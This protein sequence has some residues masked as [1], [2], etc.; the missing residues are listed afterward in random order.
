MTARLTGQS[1]DRVEG[2]RLLRGEGRFVGNI[3]HPDLLHIAFVR[4]Q[5]GHADILG[6]DTSAARSTPGVV[7]VFTAEHLDGGVAQGIAA[8][9]FERHHY[10]QDGN[11]LTAS[12]ADYLVPSAA[13]M[14][15]IEVEH[16]EVEPLHDADWRGV[17]EG[18]LIGAPAALTNAVAD[19][20][21]HLGIDICEQH[22]PHQRM[23][24]LLATAEG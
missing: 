18:G 1:V 11:L 2:P 5:L 10:D 4:S 24:Q 15:V 13:E 19:A 23:R 22:L 6:V 20:V 3:R 14:P 8:V 12:L 17:G 7:E 21:R 16:L 9:L